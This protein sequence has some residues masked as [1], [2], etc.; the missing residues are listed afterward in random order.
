MDALARV[1][2]HVNPGDAHPSVLPFLAFKVQVSA[3]SQRGQML[4][5]L[6]AFGQ[7]RVEIIL[8]CKFV[9]FPNFAIHRQP[10]QDSVLQNLTIKSWQSPGMAHRNGRQKGVR[11]SP[12]VG[13]IAAKCLG[14][15]P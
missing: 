9:V 11:Q 7:V 8:A 14:L 6:V 15:G 13:A 3:V 10:K 2:L 1:F 5:D 4:G 12:K